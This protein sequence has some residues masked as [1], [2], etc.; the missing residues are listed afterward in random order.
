MT[1]RKDAQIRSLKRQLRKAI[2]R[3]W[4]WRDR[5]IGLEVDLDLAQSELEFSE[6]FR[7]HQVRRGMGWVH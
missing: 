2:I 4:G 6:D 3:G 5:A 1:T 7:A